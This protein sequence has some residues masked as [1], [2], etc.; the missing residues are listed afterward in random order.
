ITRIHIEEDAGK[1]IHDMDPFASYIDYNRAGVPLLELVTQPD[2][3]TAQE[4]VDFIEKIRRTFVFLG[5]SDCKMQEGSLRVDVNLSVNKPG[6]SMGE[7]TE[8]KNLNSLRAVSRAIEFERARQIKILEGGGKI[9]LETR[10]WDDALGKGIKMRGKESSRDYRYFPEPDL[11]P[12]VISEEYIDKIRAN[13]PELPE[14][15]KLR[16]IKDFGLSEY[17][18]EL[19]CRTPILTRLFEQTNEFIDAPKECANWILGEYLAFCAKKDSAQ[20]ESVPEPEKMA[21]ILRFLLD[22]KI[23]RSAAKE[24]FAALC[25]SG[26]EPKKYIEENGL[27]IQNDPNLIKNAIKK[28]F[29]ENQKSVE[30]YKNGKQKVLSFLIGMC[31]KELKGRADASVLKNLIMDELNLN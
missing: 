22:G 24:V 9:E 25:E 28:V 12:L 29:C 20:E 15:K 2:I 16:F 1:L 21:D 6:E 10:K 14:A 13:M 17:D 30:E 26:A 8:T 5:I 7:R 18:A 4:A 23:S 31:M 11:S 3:R 27:F 19:L